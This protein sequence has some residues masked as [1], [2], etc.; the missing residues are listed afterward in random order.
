MCLT[1]GCWALIPQAGEQVK[2]S[3]RNLEEAWWVGS[4]VLLGDGWWLGG[5]R[6]EEGSKWSLGVWKFYFVLKKIGMGF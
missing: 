6:K 2:R 4:W 5:V 1:L 3:K